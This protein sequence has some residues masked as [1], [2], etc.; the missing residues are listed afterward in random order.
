MVRKLPNELQVVCL[1]NNSLGLTTYKYYD[2]LQIVTGNLFLAGKEPCSLP[3]EIFEIFT[4]DQ[5][6]HDLY[7]DTSETVILGTEEPVPYLLYG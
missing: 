7:V 6:P 3:V 2:D 5:P 4:D 1:Q